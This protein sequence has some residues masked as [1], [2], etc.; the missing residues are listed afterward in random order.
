MSSFKKIIPIIFILLA[1]LPSC[2]EQKLLFNFKENVNNEFFRD[3]PGIGAADYLGQPVTK[4][5]SELEVYLTTFSEK[6]FEKDGLLEYSVLNDSTKLP[7]AR[8]WSVQGYSQGL[9]LIRYPFTYT[10]ISKKTGKSFDYVVDGVVFFAIKYNSNGSTLGIMPAYFGIVN[11]EDNLI[12]FDTP[13]TLKK[14]KDN[15]YLQRGKKDKGLNG[16]LFMPADFP[17]QPVHLGQTLTI[18]KIVNLD[19]NKVGGYKPLVF[20]IAKIFRDPNAL[21]FHFIE[22]IHLNK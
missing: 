2:M 18:K 15:Y 19:P 5:A 22:T 21:E 13:L 10:I 4:S 6:Y 17:A 1:G 20:D 11:E 16:L 7:F 3:I 8:Y 12:L 14:D 9:Y